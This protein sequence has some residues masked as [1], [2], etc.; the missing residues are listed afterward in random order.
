MDSTVAALQPLF[1]A[2]GIDFEPVQRRL[3]C[4]AHIIHL[5]AS[6]ILSVINKRRPDPIEGEA[7]A[8][9]DPKEPFQ[10]VLAHAAATLNAQIN[11]EVN[12]E[13]VDAEDDGEGDLEY[14]DWTPST[15]T[16]QDIVPKVHFPSHL[17]FDWKLI[18]PLSDPSPRALDSLL[19][20]LSIVL[21]ERGS[22]AGARFHLGHHQSPC[23][24][25]YS[26]QTK[27]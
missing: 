25:S 19:P 26:S 15:D 27:R 22:R 14:F 17:A 12:Q 5:S 23:D 10:D 8:P 21:A 3:R 1:A 6:K 16:W 20:K 9:K 7:L 2:E 13:I 4:H 18:L 11:K 24:D